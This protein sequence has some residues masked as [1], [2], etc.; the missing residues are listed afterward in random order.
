MLALPTNADGWTAK[1]DLSPLFFRLTLDSSSEFLFGESVNSQLAEL[2]ESLGNT[3]QA[4]PGHRLFATAF[5]KAQ[6]HLAR[7]GRLG[8]QYWLIN[9]AEFQEACKQCHDF[10][11][12]YVQLALRKDTG[13]SD[14]ETGTTSEKKAY[15]FLEELAQQT[16]DPLE[17]RSQLLNI[18]LAGRD[19]TASLLGWVFYFLARNPAVFQ[20]LRHSILEDFGEYQDQHSITFA[21]LKNCQYLQYCLN[22]ALRMIPI[23]PL[24]SRR[25]VRDTTLPRGGGPNG[26]SPIFVEKHKAVGYSVYAM[27]RNKDLWGQ[28]AD[29]F[30]PERWIGRKAGWEFLPFNGGPRVGVSIPSPCPLANCSV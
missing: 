20:E 7:R 19:T 12:Y 2:P 30:K 9:P 24:N 29:E 21:G 8:K 28:D 1:V 15:V 25:S 14:L 5:D 17:L 23:V 6:S 4:R 16:R 27:H 3:I 11:D 26:M 22:E 13:K 18:L 10:I